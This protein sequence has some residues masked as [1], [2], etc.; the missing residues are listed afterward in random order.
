METAA[1]GQ[2]QVRTALRGENEGGMWVSRTKPKSNESKD[3]WVRQ[4]QRLCTFGNMECETEFCHCF[5]GE[6]L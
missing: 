1:L 4:G 2:Q 5:A 6:Q 3:R